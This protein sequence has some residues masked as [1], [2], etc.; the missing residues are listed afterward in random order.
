[1]SENGHSRDED[2]F[3]SGHA[4]QPRPTLCWWKGRHPVRGASVGMAG[5][6]GDGVPVIGA[7]CELGQVNVSL[8]QKALYAG[9][10][11]GDRSLLLDLAATSLQG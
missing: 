5:W 11:A 6:S 10:R 9:R 8:L 4:A 7:C 1:V 2:A 3:S